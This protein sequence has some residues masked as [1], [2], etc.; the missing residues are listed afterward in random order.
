[1]SCSVTMSRWDPNKKAE[2]QKCLDWDEKIADALRKEFGLARH[3]SESLK[4]ALDAAHGHPHKEDGTEMSAEEVAA[5]AN[6]GGDDGH[7]H[8]HGATSPLTL[9]LAITCG[10]LFVLLLALPFFFR[11][12]A[13]A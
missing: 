5:A 10:V 4:E 7:D 8:G 6:G 12:R 1:M 3:G 13:K 11:G 2:R 9:F